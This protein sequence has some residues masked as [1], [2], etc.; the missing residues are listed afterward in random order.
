M[1]HNFKKYEVVFL[2]ILKNNHRATILILILTI[3]IILFLR[4][5]KNNYKF[6]IFTIIII[7]LPV[8]FLYPFSLLYNLIHKIDEY[9]FDNSFYDYFISA[10]NSTHLGIFVTF[11]TVMVTAFT[12]M[13]GTDKYNINYLD[14]IFYKYTLKNVKKNKAIYI[15]VFL[16]VAEYI[17]FLFYSTIRN[18]ILCFTYI[19]I[20]II[21]VSIYIIYKYSLSHSKTFIENI[22]ERQTKFIINNIFKEQNYSKKRISENL[23]LMLITKYIYCLNFKNIDDV[24]FYTKLIIESF[25]NSINIFKTKMDTSIEN[26]SEK[27]FFNFFYGIYLCCKR[28]SEILLINIGDTNNTNDVIDYYI[29]ILNN[30]NNKFDNSTN[31][32][33]EKIFFFIVTSFIEPLISKSRDYYI[34]IKLIHNFLYKNNCGTKINKYYIYIILYDMFKKKSGYILNGNIDT[35]FFPNYMEDRDTEDRDTEDGDTEDGEKTFTKNYTYTLDDRNMIYYIVT[36]SIYNENNE[37]VSYEKYKNFI[38]VLNKLLSSI[39]IYEC[40][41]TDFFNNEEDLHEN[42]S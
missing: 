3:L 31:E 25:K 21:V 19:A 13:I 23:S 6:I 10:P 5:L 7:L 4:I 32:L 15:I 2:R 38:N 24:D 8:M 41:N 30:L 26:A 40:E 34:I 20:I 28:F 42:H 11:I 36:Y 1:L 37:S 27:N 14:I 9:I 33:E 17:F 16:I 12:V 22:V 18:N 39:L 35:N 29:K